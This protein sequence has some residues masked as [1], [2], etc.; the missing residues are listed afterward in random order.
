MPWHL[1][2]TLSE[3]VAPVMKFP[4]IGLLVIQAMHSNHSES[5]H[6]WA[7]KF[8]RDL[9]RLEVS[10]NQAAQKSQKNSKALEKSRVKLSFL[11]S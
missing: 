2:R 4:A 1:H 11:A 9:N 8:K 5:A 6:T 7:P 10:A 3:G